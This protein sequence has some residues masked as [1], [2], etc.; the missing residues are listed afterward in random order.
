M[1][2]MT[3][4]KLSRSIWMNL[5]SASGLSGCGRVAGEI[6][7][8]ADDERQL[9]LDLGAFGLHLVGDVHA[10]LA[11]AIQLVVDTGA[12]RRDPPAYRLLWTGWAVHGA[13][14]RASAC[15][16]AEIADSPAVA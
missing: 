3:S 6:A 12:H 7:H 15:K 5:R 10:R 11:H 4:L 2:A 9:A 1:R 8:D 13:G 16:A 14:R